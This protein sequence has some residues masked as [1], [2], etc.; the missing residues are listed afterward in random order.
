MKVLLP[1]HGYIDWNG[2]I[3]LVRLIVSAIDHQTAAAP[4]ELSFAL[5]TPA[6]PLKGIA[7]STLRRCRELLAGHTD[8]TAGRAS[9]LLKA[10]EEITSG[11][12]VI[13][14]SDNAAGI[15]GAAYATHADIVFP[16]MYSLGSDPV[17]RIGYIFDFQHRHLPELFPKRTRVNRDKQF[18]RIANE[19]TGIVVNA[20]TVAQ[21]LERFLNISASQVLVMPFSPY[22]HPW[23]FDLDTPSAQAR[24]GIHHT[25]VMVCNHF[26]KH[27]DHITALRAFA[28]LRKSPEMHDLQLVMTGD[29]IDHRDPAHFHRLHV[30]CDELGIAQSTHFLGLIPKRDQLALLRGSGALMQPTLFE[31]GPGGGS[32]YEAIGFG[33]PAVVSDIPVNLEIDQGDVRFFCTG[34]AEDLAAKTAEI[35]AHPMPRPDRDVL[36]ARGDANLV[37]LGNA[38][39]HYLSQMPSR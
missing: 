23:W 4:I 39:C 1:L 16:T 33:V 8:S 3:D 26:W 27:K 17:K 37:R 5:P 32:V 25:Y 13:R 15:L 7:L 18:R 28:T 9:G 6:L 20:R 21:D 30:L 24:Y 10:A 35:L 12:T 11:R 22:A 29:P 31:G 38:I 19:S 2:G 34:N 36:L 14:C